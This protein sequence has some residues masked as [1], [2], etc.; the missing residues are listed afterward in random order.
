MTTGTLSSS[1]IRS[2]QV[3]ELRRNER[4][5]AA[6]LKATTQTDNVQTRLAIAADLVDAG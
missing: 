5:N 4:F 6:T 2:E 1:A 3:E